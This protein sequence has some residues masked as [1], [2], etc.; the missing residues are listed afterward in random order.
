MYLLDFD[1]TRDYLNIPNFTELEEHFINREDFIR[2]GDQKTEE[3]RYIL[4]DSKK[5]VGKT[6]LSFYDLQEDKRDKYYNKWVCQFTS[7]GVSRAFGAHVYDFLFCPDKRLN[8]TFKD[9]KAIMC[10]VTRLESSIYNGRLPTEEQL[11]R[12]IEDMYDIV[13][14]PMFYKT[15]FKNQYLALTENLNKNLVLYNKEENKLYAS[16]WGNS[17]SRKITGG[18]IKMGKYSKPEDKERVINY[19]L[20]HYSIQLMPCYYVELEK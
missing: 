16:Y 9:E 20:A 5:H 4:L 10:G 14:V 6:C 17:L 7:A 18:S 19:V 8:A 11:E 3:T 1:I 15:G 13:D 12:I 2:E